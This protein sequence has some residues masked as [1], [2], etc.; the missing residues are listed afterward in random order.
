MFCSKCGKEIS[1]QAKFCNFCGAQTNV[2]QPVQPQ[3][4]AAPRKKGKTGKTVL[5][6]VLVAAVFF[7]TKMISQKF[8]S[9]TQNNDSGF[10]QGVKEAITVDQDIKSTMESCSYGALYQ[11]GS[12]RYGMTKLNAP[13]YF[14]LAG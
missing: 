13:G 6:I 9:S 4:T 8:V 7:G 1:D 14:L 5:S 11:N 10:E 2:A 12:F 3:Q